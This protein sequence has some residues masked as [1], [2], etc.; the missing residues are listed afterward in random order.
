MYVVYESRL[1]LLLQLA[2][3]FCFT[4][5]H[6]RE[7]KKRKTWERTELQSERKRTMEQIKHLST[8]DDLTGLP[9]R[10][11]F[12]QS[13]ET[14]MAKAKKNGDPLAVLLIDMDRFKLINDSFGQDYGDML[15]LQVAE[16]L[17][18]FV[19]V[20]DF[21]AR[22][23]GDEYALYFYGAD[24]DKVEQ[25]AEA[26]F[27]VMEEFFHIQ[28]VD[29]PLSISVGISVSSNEVDDSE[30]MMK[31]ADAALSQA[32][33]FGRNNYQFYADSMHVS[34]MER[35][36]LESELRRAMQQN[37]FELYYQPQ[38]NMKQGKIVG[39]EAL[40]RWNHPERGVVS[41]GTFI[42]IAEE[43]GMIG[44][45]G[46]WVLKEACHQ[47]KHWQEQGYEHVPVSV[48]LSTRQF[49]QKE[50][51]GRVA[52]I[53]AQ[54]GLNPRYL[55][56]EITESMT[57]DMAH[58]I[59]TLNELKNLGILISMDDF[60]TGYS[61]LSLLKKIPI[62]KLKI[63]QTFIRDLFDDPS[64][65]A[66]VSTII[67]IAR[68]L[69]LKVVAEGVETK[70]QMEYLYRNHCEEVQGYLFSPP[71]PVEQFELFMQR[72]SNVHKD[73]IKNIHN[74]PERASSYT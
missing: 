69:N 16:R 47:N 52:K 1:L 36:T 22:M 50:L 19:T 4:A 64:D 57:M 54:T 30:L 11:L 21:I 37:E 34:S 35:L 74:R 46:E 38:I 9:N 42:P 41:P 5:V 66:I 7:H 3:M 24:Q 65:A 49:K 63:D 70:E 25:K 73:L 15:L 31:L 67:S 6:Y 14:A 40:I 39:V 61:S 2:A 10:R 56:L 55:E 28:G 48:N 18:R 43:T 29:I 23:E 44:P 51:S 71:L 62:A 60:G 13:L 17:T 53:L 27:K 68:N 26:I 8:Y 32:K 72:F 58:A 12:R 20:H 59:Q 45:I 33:D